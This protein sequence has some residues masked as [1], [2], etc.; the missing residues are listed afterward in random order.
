MQRD[1]TAHL[2]AWL[3]SKTDDRHGATVTSYALVGTYGKQPLWGKVILFNK[4]VYTYPLIQR[5]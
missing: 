3:K 2:P 1:R 4:T 5:V